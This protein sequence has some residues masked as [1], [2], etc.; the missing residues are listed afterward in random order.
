MSIP[1]HAKKL[2]IMMPLYTL[3]HCR[4]PP[5]RSCCNILV[6]VKRCWTCLEKVRR[7]LAKTSKALILNLQILVFTRATEKCYTFK[8]LLI[9]SF[10]LL[11]LT[12]NFVLH[13]I[14]IHFLLS[15]FL[16]P[17]PMPCPVSVLLPS[18]A[19]C[20]GLIKILLARLHSHPR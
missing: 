9:P 12:T 19:A 16:P 4:V 3:L 20:Q 10:P 1:I 6:L 14:C 8:L 2:N 5:W 17:L 11:Q 15:F 7:K 13:Y 18:V